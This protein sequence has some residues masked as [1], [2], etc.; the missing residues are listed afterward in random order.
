MKARL[1]LLALLVVGTAVFF[2]VKESEDAVP[3]V[4]SEHSASLTHRH[5]SNL[6]GSNTSD[7]LAEKDAPKGALKV[8]F[9][10]SKLAWAIFQITL[11][12]VVFKSSGLDFTWE[13][14]MQTTNVDFLKCVAQNCFAEGVGF[15][16]F[17]VGNVIAGQTPLVETLFLIWML[18]V[19]TPGIVLQLMYVKWM[20]CPKD[21]N[22]FRHKWTNCMTLGAVLG[23]IAMLL[24]GSMPQK[25]VGALSFEIPDILRSVYAIALC[26]QAEFTDRRK[27]GW[28]MVRHYAL[29]Y[30]INLVVNYLNHV[31]DVSTLADQSLLSIGGILVSRSLAMLGFCSQAKLSYNLTTLGAFLGP[32][33]EK[34][35]WQTWT[36]Q[37]V[38][39][40]RLHC[41]GVSPE[42]LWTWSY[43][44]YFFAYLLSFTCLVTVTKPDMD[45][46]PIYHMYKTY[47][48]CM[49]L[50][51]L[52][53]TLLAQPFFV[54]Q[55]F[56]QDAAVMFSFL[57]NVIFGSTL[58]TIGSAIGMTIWLQ[59]S[60]CFVLVFTFNPGATS[61]M[62]HSIPYMGYVFAIAT[63]FITELATVS[64]RF[65]MGDKEV[66]NLG[67]FYGYVAFV[68]AMICYGENFM[69]S[70]FIKNA[71]DVYK[72]TGDIDAE[73]EVEF[74]PLPFIGAIV[75]DTLYVIWVWMTPHAKYPVKMM[76]SSFSNLS[77]TDHVESVTCRRTLGTTVRA[78]Y[79]GFL[80]MLAALI[81]AGLA[82]YLN[83]QVDPDASITFREN[84]ERL[85]GSAFT[86]VFWVVSSLFLSLYVLI[87]M[88]HETY[89]NDNKNVILAVQGIG[90]MLIMS[91]VYA[92]GST[93]PDAHSWHHYGA[94]FFQTCFTVWMGVMLVVLVQHRRMVEMR[95][96]VPEA[97]SCV[98]A[99]VALLGSL[100]LKIPAFDLGWIAA[101][102]FY[103][104]NDSIGRTLT[105][106]D[107]HVASGLQH[108]DHGF[109]PC[110]V[111]ANEDHLFNLPSHDLG[112][113][114]DG[115]VD[116]A[117]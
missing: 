43:A 32:E 4:V 20:D 29:W 25:A 34:S 104:M 66:G 64:R 55:V 71:R 91:T 2:M 22:Y 82:V 51:Y 48:P 30:V 50:D 105:V 63:F 80:A 27:P 46:S 88:F 3:P 41:V 113:L 17:F 39:R 49:L 76:L 36:L 38:H 67:P 42:R 44:S 21:E 81:G 8:V 11:S 24:H 95:W 62:A 13:V 78:K 7:Q 65:G 68:C 112:Q 103:L 90:C 100:V 106:S 89:T 110:W 97:L 14:W 59:C 73:G 18:S 35:A 53:G 96:L 10:G 109:K 9:L 31:Y 93:I 28:A 12:I 108:S 57:R 37:G 5:D 61:V 1:V 23:F 85:P 116:E 83:H 114:D 102:A 117:R 115:E 94:E 52:P 79:F 77:P 69:L 99:I 72:P 111:H 75:V 98:L 87:V 33:K 92:F 101:F 26:L 45:K 15:V 54:L 74:D 56:M 70:T 86:A 40:N 84:F 58:L 16:I 6:L 60:T 47:H 19:T 107:V